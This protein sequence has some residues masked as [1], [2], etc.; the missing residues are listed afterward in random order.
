MSNRITNGASLMKAFGTTEEGL[1]DLPYPISGTRISRVFAE[2]RG[3]CGYCFPHG[4][5]SPNSRWKKDHRSWKR[6]R[7]TQYRATGIG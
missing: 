4:W 1:V 7:K 6:C 2:G 5:E 3:E